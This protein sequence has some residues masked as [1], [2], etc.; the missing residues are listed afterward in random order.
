MG[1]SWVEK[2]DNL[3]STLGRRPELNELLDLCKDHEMTTVELEAQR[4]S[5][6]IGI[7]AR[8]QHGEVDFE[9]C[10]RCREREW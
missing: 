5:W 8:C 1:K 7:T 10:P 4:E 3:T 2:V 9:Q 6:A